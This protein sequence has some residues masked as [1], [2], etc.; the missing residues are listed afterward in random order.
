MLGFSNP[1]FNPA[2][3]IEIKSIIIDNTPPIDSLRLIFFEMEISMLSAQ[4][5]PNVRSIIVT[6]LFSYFFKIGNTNQ[7]NYLKEAVIMNS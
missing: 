6:G 1:P 2:S 4:N 3:T 5:N 7:Q